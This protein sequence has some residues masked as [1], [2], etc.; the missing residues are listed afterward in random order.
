MPSTLRTRLLATATLTLLVAAGVGIAPLSASAITT[1][2]NVSTPTVV[3]KVAVGRI[4]TPHATVSPADS[5]LVFTW[6][7]DGVVV[8]PDAVAIAVQPGW[9]NKKLTL[10]VTG[11]ADGYTPQSRTS[12]AHSVAKGTIKAAIAVTGTR[13]VGSSLGVVTTGSWSPSSPALSVKWLRNGKA[14]AGQNGPNYFLVLADNGKRNDVKM[15]ISSPGFTTLVLTTHTKTKT[16][17]PLIPVAASPQISGD[18]VYGSTLTASHGAW[19]VVPTSFSYQWKIGSK[20][21]AHATHQTFRL[22]VA[23][24]GKPVT[25]VVTAR[26]AGYAP[27]AI[28]SSATDTVLPREFDSQPIPTIVGSHSKGHTLTAKLIGVFS[29]KAT[30]TYS[31]YSNGVRIPHATKKTY[32]VTSTTVGTIIDIV[33][34]GHRPGYRTTY[35]GTILN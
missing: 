28:P 9:V 25:V 35:I 17:L 33:I 18:L 15:T 26:H 13:R 10:T 23:A 31:W 5:N 2:V 20:K 12:K 21:V 3:G 30:L 27:T 16:A 34:Y 6:K 1:T 19:D 32:K 14:L 29:P 8:W 4:L 22:P 11:S 7:I 24:V